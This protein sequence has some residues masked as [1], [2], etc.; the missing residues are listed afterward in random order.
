MQLVHIITACKKWNVD[1]QKSFVI[2]DRWRDIGAGKFAGCKTVFLKKNY[3]IND[4]TRIKPDYTVN[5]LK[6][7]QKIIPLY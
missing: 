6:Y 7:L 5:N 3:N 4:L 2:G 1:L